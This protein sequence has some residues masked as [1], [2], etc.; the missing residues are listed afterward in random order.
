M[1]KIKAK[2]PTKKPTKLSEKTKKPKTSQPDHSTFP[3]P[4]GQ[5]V[6]LDRSSVDQTPDQQKFESRP[7]LAQTPMTAMTYQQ[8]PWFPPMA[9]T[10]ASVP[11]NLPS[12][13]TGGPDQS[14]G[15]S[16]MFGGLSADQ[17]S[18]Q[19]KFASRPPLAQ[20]PMTAMTYQQ[21]PWFPQMA[22]T[23]ASVPTNL[24]SLATGGL[25][26]SIGQSFLL[27]SQQS[28]GYQAPGQ[29]V[30]PTVYYSQGS[31]Q[32]ASRSSDQSQTQKISQQTQQINPP[33]QP[34]A[35]SNQQQIPSQKPT[36]P[37]CT[38][39]KTESADPR[40]ALKEH[41][42][43][44]EFPDLGLPK[45]L[46]DPLSS[47]LED[48][49]PPIL[50]DFL[51][52]TPEKPSKHEFLK[53]PAKEIPSETDEELVLLPTFVLEFPNKW[54]FTDKLVDYTTIRFSNWD[55]RWPVKRY[56]ALSETACSNLKAVKIYESS[57]LSKDE[58]M[59]NLLRNLGSLTSLQTLEIDTLIVDLSKFAS[60]ET[61]P[62]DDSLV[63]VRTMPEFTFE[64]LIKLSIGC[65]ELVGGRRDEKLSI[66]APELRR[67]FLGE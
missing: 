53:L 4:V 31:S 55:G 56:L 21:L 57:F 17:T 23:A 29:P 42:L 46:N 20:T 58:K 49:E 27:P 47:S 1:P 34:S 48:R 3:Q 16:M 39:Q 43:R 14:I 35:R 36:Q 66:N 67:V 26:Q 54:M 44:P 50:L 15:Q 6:Q 40:I 32:V 38:Q 5:P 13:A 62:A 41:K 59:I 11:T 22:G 52:G 65:V 64:S 10:A 61:L 2:K 24:P 45:E 63:K 18:D 7:P 19:Q 12:L 60:P 30:Y 51:A 25:D 8:L 28:Y 33:P 37:I 9:G